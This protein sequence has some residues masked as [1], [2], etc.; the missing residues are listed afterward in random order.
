MDRTSTISGDESAMWSWAG[1]RKGKGAVGKL[2]GRIEVLERE[3]RML[4]AALMAV[5]RTGGALNGCPCRVLGNG[6]RGRMNGVGGEESVRSSGGGSERTGSE[7]NALE[8]YLGT[9][10]GF[11]DGIGGERVRSS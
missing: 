6:E 7:V 8:V 11:G 4:E 2:E 5:L 9:R 1:E 10:R 3:N